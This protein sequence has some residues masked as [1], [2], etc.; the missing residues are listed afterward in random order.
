MAKKSV[1][2]GLLDDV[3][4]EMAAVR[5]GPARWHDR[6]APEHLAELKAI[7]AAWKAGEL[8]EHKKPLARSLSKNMRKRGISD[9]GEQ[10]VISWLNAD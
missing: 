6:V 8:G 5:V 3:R 2:G 4:E 10:G 7:K 9:V 1:S